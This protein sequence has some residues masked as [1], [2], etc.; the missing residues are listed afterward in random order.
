[1][2]LWTDEAATART[3]SADLAGY[4]DKILFD[5]PSMA[6]Y[7]L[8]L[9]PWAAV[10]GTSEAALRS[11]SALAAVATVPF[12]Y[13]AGLRLGGRRVAVAAAAL[14]VANAFVLRYALEARSYALELLLITIATWLLIRNADPEREP[15]RT[16]WIL[17]AVA[18][19]AAIWIHLYAVFAAAAHAV[20]LWWLGGPARRPGLRA[21]GMAVLA[22]VPV[23]IAIVVWGP[24][25]AWL[26]A[27][28]FD[29]ALETLATLV[30]ATERGLA[31]T[32]LSVAY[33]AAVAATAAVVARR[34]A[35]HG[36]RAAGDRW[37]LLLAIAVPVGAGLAVSTVKPIFVDRSLI[38]TVPAL[39]LLLASAL[40][41]I[42]RTWPAAA[43][44]IAVLALST[45]QAMHGTIDKAD[46][47]GAIDA[48]ASEARA[49]DSLL[50]FPA[51]HSSDA[52]RYYAAREPAL[53]DMPIQDAVAPLGEAAD[54]RG[55]I[56][57]LAYDVPPG[58]RIHDGAL[59]RELSRRGYRLE[60]TR[61]FHRLT[62]EVYTPP[63]AAVE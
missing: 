26:D 48:V 33:L 24:V 40:A 60:E 55:R 53:A 9:R 19:A 49:G 39:H 23:T 17:Y 63:A 42:P 18:L 2:S 30:G 59:D 1:V 34:W 22:A 37:L 20:W 61:P 41:L 52:A 16:A 4:V 14:L 10:F 54:G 11:L 5:E 8:V 13:L 58:V 32:L 3:M 35:P 28:T 36:D 38:V 44:L 7:Y 31:G 21:A 56:W 43:V 15:S 46:W 50:V 62:L 51:E 27:P 25:R 29:S 6:G 12:L 57:L 47:R 45:S